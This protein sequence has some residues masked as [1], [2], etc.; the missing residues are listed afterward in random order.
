[1]SRNVQPA[2]RPLALVAATLA[3]V[4]CGKAPAPAAKPAVM[5]DPVPA[6]AQEAAKAI[7]GDVLRQ[8]VTEISDDRYE[9]RAPGTRGDVLAR[10]WLASELGKIGF[11][12]GGADGSWEQ[13]FDLVGIKSQ[14]PAKWT[15]KVGRK[16]V[17]YKWWD[18]YIGA[19]GT[20]APTSAIKD[21][22]LV[23]VGY[24]IEAPEYQWNDFKGQ[25]L[26]GKVLVMLN[27]DPDWDPALFAGVTRL[28]YGR[29]M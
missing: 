21:A 24:G 20:Q 5:P 28:Y 8:A 29:W 27:S 22:E 9:G 16:R 18:D 23:F 2:C 7:T 3:L 14:M 15:F 26:K 13:P 6:A 1:M 10:R 25:D 12:P 19:S 4:A 17:D 11:Q